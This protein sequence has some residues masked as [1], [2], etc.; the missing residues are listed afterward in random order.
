MNTGSTATTAKPQS[1]LVAFLRREKVLGAALLSCLLVLLFE[2]PLTTGFANPFKLVAVLSW[3]FIIILATAIGVVRHA[4]A[5]SSRLGEPFGTLVLTLSITGIEVLSITAVMLHG[6]NNPA[7]VR[8]TLFSVVMI[9]MGGMVGISLLLGAFRHKELSFNLQGAN[10]YLGVIIP[11]AVFSLVLPDFSRSSEGPTLSALQKAMVGLMAAGLYIIF[12]LIQTGRHRTFFSLPQVEGDA[13]ELHEETEASP[14]PVGISLLLLVCYIAP[15]VFL[16][17]TLAKPVDYIIETLHMPVAI[18]GVMMAI[19]VTTPEGIGGVKA[20]L[21]N[22][23]QQ[24]VNI[25][26]GSVLATIGLTVP[27]MLALSSAL[28]LDLVLGLAGI[29]VMMLILIFTVSIVTFSSGRTHVLQ[30]AVHFL[31]FVAFLML[32]YRG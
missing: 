9:I 20:A 30:G 12:L 19:L 2:H 24:S 13:E 10:A 31:I 29:D 28:G 21:A 16:V 15:I 23:L 11:L 14:Y 1:P 3:L 17:E 22:R 6:E 5:L 25:F 27:I 32:L 26:L 4:E 8:D 18:G 7:L